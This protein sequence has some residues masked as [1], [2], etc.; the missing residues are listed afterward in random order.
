MVWCEKGLNSLKGNRRNEEIGLKL[1]R[2][3]KAPPSMPLSATI[4]E[5]RHPAWSPFLLN[6]RK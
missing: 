2:K 1:I 4:T 6:G 5:A 3:P